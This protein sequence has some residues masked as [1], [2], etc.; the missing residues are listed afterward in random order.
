MT[1][2][3]AR[4]YYFVACGVFVGIF[5]ILAFWNVAFLA[6]YNPPPVYYSLLAISLGLVVAGSASLGL[7]DVNEKLDKLLEEKKQREESPKDEPNP[8]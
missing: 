3:R 5:V 6:P 8:S 7:A 4:G 2:Y 1:N